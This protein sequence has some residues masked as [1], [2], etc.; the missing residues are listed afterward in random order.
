MVYTL[1]SW[2]IDDPGFRPIG[3]SM[4]MSGRTTKSESSAPKNPL[5]RPEPFPQLSRLSL[6]ICLSISLSLDVYRLV[7]RIVCDA[8]GDC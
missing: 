1:V 6:S 3:G 4:D 5:E 8:K 2:Q 7:P